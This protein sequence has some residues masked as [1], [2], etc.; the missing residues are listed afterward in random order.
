MKKPILIQDWSITTRSLISPYTPPEMIKS[1]LRGSVVDHPRFPGI[2]F[3]TTSSIANV[4]K[5]IITTSSGTIYRLGKISNPYRKWL[6]K[7]R[8]NWD[9]RKPITMRRNS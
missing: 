2:Q 1:C 8:P 3:V 9:W 4:K 5:R 6:K 7:N